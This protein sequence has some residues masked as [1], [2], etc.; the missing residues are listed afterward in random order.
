VETVTKAIQAA[1]WQATADRGDTCI[2]IRCPIKLKEKLHEKRRARQLWQLTKSPADKQ[3]YNRLAKEIKKLTFQLKNDS[4]Q[5]YL[6][7]LT[8]TEATKYSLWK[9]T[10]KIKQSKQQIPPIRKSDNNWS[11]KSYYIRRTS[12]CS[13]P[14]FTITTPSSW[15]GSLQTA[16]DPF[17][18][19]TPINK[20]NHREVE[21]IILLGISSRKAPG[22]E[23]ITDK[24]LKN[25]PDKGFRL[26]TYIYNAILRLEYFPANGK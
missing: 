11:A 25:L 15:R 5:V 24:I 16:W 22:Y 18:D 14:T 26:L 17:P 2:T 8:P 7:G 21:I 19:G 6:R 20:I 9:A 13:L 1:A 23:L 4:I 10:R 12:M 3:T